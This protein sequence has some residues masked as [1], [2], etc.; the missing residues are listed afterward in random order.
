MLAGRGRDATMG[1]VNIRVNLAIF[2][3]WLTFAA[4]LTLPT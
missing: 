2:I 3:T 1:S 4:I